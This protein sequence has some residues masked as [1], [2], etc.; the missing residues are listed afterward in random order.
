MIEIKLKIEDIDYD[1]VADILAPALKDRIDGSEF[2]AW[3]RLLFLAGGMNGDAFKKILSRVPKDA[4]DDFVVKLLNEKGDKT[5]EFLE[6]I[7]S[8]KGVNIKISDV[9]AYKG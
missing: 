1:S 6:E 9:K 2:P 7:A 4:I 5:A 3:A 8:S